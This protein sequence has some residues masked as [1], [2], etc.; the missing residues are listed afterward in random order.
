MNLAAQQEDYL[1]EEAREKTYK[2][3]INKPKYV[4]TVTKETEKIK[5]PRWIRSFYN[6]PK[7]ENKF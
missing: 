4:N 5:A 3:K 6:Y 7:E 2:Q 1:L